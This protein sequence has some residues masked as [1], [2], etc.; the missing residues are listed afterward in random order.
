MRSAARNAVFG[1]AAAV[2][3]TTGVERHTVGGATPPMARR[4]RRFASPRRIFGSV[5]PGRPLRQWP[6]SAIVG[7]GVNNPARRRPATA[8]SDK[9][10]HRGRRAMYPPE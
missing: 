1:K 2:A 7:T 9:L 10:L 5:P 4:P 8:G 6:D 3:Q